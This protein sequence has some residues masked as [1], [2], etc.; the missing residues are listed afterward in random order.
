MTALVRLYGTRFCPYCTAARRLLADR[1][2][3]FDDIAVDGNPELRATMERESGRRTV[4]QIWIGR[5]HVGGFDDLN[6][7]DRSGQLLPLV[8]SES[9]G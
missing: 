6:A 9:A 5:R 1:G 7:L 3:A 8:A 4:P 2:I